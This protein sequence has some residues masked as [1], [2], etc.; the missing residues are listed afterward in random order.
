MSC[1][2]FDRSLAFAVLL[3]TAWSLFAV[4][5]TTAQAQSEKTATAAVRA[6]IERLFDGM[7]D[8]NSTAVRAV[9]AKN[10]TLQTAMAS[11]D[12]SVVRVMPLRAFVDA[13]GRPHDEVWDERTWDVE[14]RV[15]GPMAS[16]WVPYAFYRGDSLSHCGVNAIQLVRHTT[17]WRILH[18]LDTRTPAVAC[19]VPDAVTSARD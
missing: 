13:V 6:S 12:S 18:L 11:G 17:G 7:R 5:A 4:Q 19:S 16:A 8:G 14:V 9:F 1:P 3:T 10:A 15:D 2:V